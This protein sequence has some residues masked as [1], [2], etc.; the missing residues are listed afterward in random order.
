MSILLH[1][2]TTWT[3]TK[4][5]ERKLDGNCT[6]M[7]PAVLNKFWRQHPTKQ[8]LNGHLPPISKTIQTKRARFTGHCWR[9]KGKLISD[10]PLWTLS[11]GRARIGWPAR[12]YLQQLCTDTRCNMKTC[13][14]RWTIGTSGRRGSGKSV[15]AV[16]NDDDDDITHTVFMNLC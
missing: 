14:K 4:H 2:C 8:Q 9:S 12:A 11:H 16:R 10:V 15:P 13:R 6:K 1:R 7:L 5:M 3:L